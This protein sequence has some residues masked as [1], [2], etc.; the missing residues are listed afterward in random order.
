MANKVKFGLKS[1]AYALATF[2]SD[3]TVSYGTPVMLPGSV[4]IS[5]DPQGDMTT[6]RADNVDYWVG[7]SNRGYQ[8]DYENA[9]L[10]DSFRKDVLQESVDA[11]GLLLE[12]VNSDL[13]HFA[14]L[15]QV[16]GDKSAARHVLYNCT[17]G[18]VSISGETTGETTEPQTDTV[19]ITAHPITFATQNRPVVKARV[20]E[21][22]ASTAY[23]SWFSAVQTPG[24]PAA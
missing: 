1:A 8:G 4:S 18:R 15:F 2:A 10:P 3:G 17:A 16:E 5:L 23:T 20:E 24:A 14:F 6:F 21:T 19:Q 13:K 7:Q 22:T 11:N 12:T 9:L